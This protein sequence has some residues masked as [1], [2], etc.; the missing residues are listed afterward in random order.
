[1]GRDAIVD[2]DSLKSDRDE[3][4][5]VGVFWVWGLGCHV[6]AFDLGFRRFALSRSSGS[7]HSRLGFQLH[8][9]NLRLLP[10]T[11][12]EDRWEFKPVRVDACWL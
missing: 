9:H 4:F 8:S 2:T 6:R 5:Q 7:R 1:M 11:R 12:L 10:K 3:G